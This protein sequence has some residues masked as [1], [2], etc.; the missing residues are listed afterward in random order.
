MALA[1]LPLVIPMI[2]DLVRDIRDL[3]ALMRADS[4]SPEQREEQLDALAARLDA[5]L[6]EVESYQFRTPPPISGT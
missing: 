2:P 3:V 4:L 5:R 1:L 6:L